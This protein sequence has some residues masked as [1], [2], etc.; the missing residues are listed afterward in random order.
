MSRWQKKQQLCHIYYVKII[1]RLSIN[2]VKELF[3]AHAIDGHKRKACNLEFSPG[4]YKAKAKY[5]LKEL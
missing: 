2:Q 4:P 1:S 3:E 5:I